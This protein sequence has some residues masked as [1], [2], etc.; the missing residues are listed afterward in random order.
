[1]CVKESRSED[2]YSVL[3]KNENE[4]KRSVLQPVLQIISTMACLIIGLKADIFD[5]KN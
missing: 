1:M 5:R 3:Q 2:I 4:I